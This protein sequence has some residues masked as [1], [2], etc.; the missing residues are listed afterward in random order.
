MQQVATPD[1]LAYMVLGYSVTVGILILMV[2]YMAAKARRMRSD[3]QML[4][5]LEADEKPKRG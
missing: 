2:A 5:T 4:E 1:T 3:I